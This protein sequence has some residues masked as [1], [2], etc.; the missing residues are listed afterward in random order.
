M[1]KTQ[2]LFGLP[3]ARRSNRWLVVAVSYATLTVVT[4]TTVVEFPSLQNLEWVLAVTWNLLLWQFLRSLVEGRILPEWRPVELIGLGIG[5]RRRGEGAPD[6]RDVAVRNAACFQAYRV[7][8][9]YV[10]GL[11]LVA[12]PGLDSL[13][14]PSALRLL[15]QLLIPLLPIALTLPYA[16]VLWT[17][18][19]VQEDAAA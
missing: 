15:R 16:V 17:E 10:L 18:P 4:L 2:L 14:A 3:L 5:R 1:V 8:A 19:D 9:V 6:Q 12:L 13:A 11:W 7:L